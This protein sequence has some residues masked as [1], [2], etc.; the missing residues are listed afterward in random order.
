MEEAPTLGKMAENIRASINSTRNMVS[1]PIHGKMAES[2]L[3]NGEIARDTAGVKL[4]QLMAVKGKVF[5]RKTLRLTIA[6]RR[7][8]T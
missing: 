4:F 3:E 8:V 5:G 7:V 1:V 6:R 2:T